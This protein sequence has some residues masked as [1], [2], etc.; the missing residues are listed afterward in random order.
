MEYNVKL[1]ERKKKGEKM[2]ERNGQCSFAT[3]TSSHNLSPFS[4]K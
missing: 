3:N 1:F 4:A 2:G